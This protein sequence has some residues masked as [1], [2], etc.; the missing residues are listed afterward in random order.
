[1]RVSRQ[2]GLGAWGGWCS[3]RRR[4]GRG[5]RSVSKKNVALVTT[6]GVL[7]GGVL[8]FMSGDNYAT[9]PTRYR[10]LYTC[11]NATPSLRL[12]G[13]RGGQPSRSSMTLGLKS[14]R[15]LCLGTRAGAVVRYGCA[16][17]VPARPRVGRAG[18][19]PFFR[20]KLRA[21]CFYTH[22]RRQK[23]AFCSANDARRAEHR[24]ARAGDLLRATFATRGRSMHRRGP[25][26]L[27]PILS[28]R[29]QVTVC[30]SVTTN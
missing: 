23:G 17:A 27:R 4:R 13:E 8:L 21:S 29:T 2:S 26:R 18:C 30:I 20:G 11:V 10:H 1:M 3:E 28:V 5:G 7:G 25:W 15:D 14:A 19:S 24:R 6:Q 16:I 22:K 9:V 12:S